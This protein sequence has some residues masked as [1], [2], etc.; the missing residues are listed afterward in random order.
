MNLFFWMLAVF[1][2]KALSVAFLTQSSGN[3]PAPSAPRSSSPEDASSAAAAPSHSSSIALSKQQH[4]HLKAAAAPSQSSS[5]AISKQQHRHF[6]HWG[7][8]TAARG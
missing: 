6:N 1:G 7:A 4:R 5:I 8:G 2:Q 3:T